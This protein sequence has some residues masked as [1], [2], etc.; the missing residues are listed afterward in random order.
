MRKYNS[1]ICSCDNYCQYSNISDVLLRFHQF[2]LVTGNANFRMAQTTFTLVGFTQP[3][4]AL[5]IIQDAQNNNAKGI[6]SRLLWFFPKP[7]FCKISETMLSEDK[8]N[9]LHTFKRQLGE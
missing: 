2:C 8:A 6:T 1:Y 9:E 7:V 4:T 5:P 3:H